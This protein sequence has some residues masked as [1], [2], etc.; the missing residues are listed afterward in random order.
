MGNYYIYVDDV[1]EDNGWFKK[2]LEKDSYIPIVCKTYES[3]VQQLEEI[4]RTEP[5]ANIFLDLDHDLGELEWLEGGIPVEV[6]GIDICS[7][8]IENGIKLSG[9]RIHSTNRLGKIRMRQ[10][11]GKVGYKEYF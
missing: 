7:Y 3:T 5:Q 11:L 6:T 10:I 2:H 1:R 8:V 4:L 9:F